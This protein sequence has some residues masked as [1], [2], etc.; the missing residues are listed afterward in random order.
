MTVAELFDTPVKAAKMIMSVAI[1]C[2]AMTVI[3]Y[4]VGAGLALLPGPVALHFVLLF[5]CVTLLAYLEGLQVAIL[6]LENL[7]YTVYREN[8]PSGCKLM[9]RATQPDAVKKFLCG[10][11]F[12]V[13]FV[14]FLMAQLTTFPDFPSGGMPEWLFI[15][16][17]DTGL[18]GALFVLMWGQLLPQITAADY[19]LQFCGLPGSMAVLYLCLGFEFLGVTDVSWLLAAG[20][21]TVSGA[22]PKAYKKRER[23]AD[24]TWKTAEQTA[25]QQK[26]ASDPVGPFAEQLSGPSEY[27]AVE[28]YTNIKWEAIFD[29]AQKADPLQGGVT[30]AQKKFSV[31]DTVNSYPSPPELAKYLMEHNQPVPRF[32]LPVTHPMHIPP[33]LVAAAELLKQNFVE[34]SATP[35]STT[36]A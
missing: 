13:V 12:F 24:G 28:D 4:G 23:N 1:L 26:D 30:S 6:A 3:F 8:Y 5:G 11:Q 2:G 33:H 35:V 18:S 31:H 14:V 32:L 21:A 27:D 7:D 9:D 22:E 10:R 36:V 20:A 29:T 34:E 15:L 19:P 25:A 16:C 17:I